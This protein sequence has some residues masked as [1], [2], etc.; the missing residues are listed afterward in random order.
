MFL[1]TDQLSAASGRPG[2][3]LTG[4]ANQKNGEDRHVCCAD[5]EALVDVCGGL[6]KQKHAPEGEH[7]C[8]TAE[9]AGHRC[10]PWRPALLIGGRALRAPIEV[11]AAGPL[12][13]SPTSKLAI[14]PSHH[15]TINDSGTIL[16]RS[17]A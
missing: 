1:G 9:H 15:R 16:S 3:T 6:S 4:G 17:Y 2:A 13:P 5:I 12:D 7:V 14:E 10:A 8:C 11:H